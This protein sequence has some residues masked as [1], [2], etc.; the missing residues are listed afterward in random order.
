MKRPLRWLATPIVSFLLALLPLAGF[1]Q[2]K[3]L[4]IDI[5]G[6][7][8]AALPSAVGP[9]AVQGPGAAPSTD[10]A[11]VLRA[12]CGGSGQFRT[13]PD[14]DRDAHHTRGRK[15]TGAARVGR[16]DGVD[17][18]GRR[19]MG[20][21]II[22]RGPGG[23]VDHEVVAGH[24]R[25]TGVRI[26]DVQ[27][28]AVDSSHVVGAWRLSQRGDQVLPEH[29][30]AADDQPATHGFVITVGLRIRRGYRTHSMFEE[31]DRGANQS[32]RWI[33]PTGRPCGSS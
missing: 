5:V 23:D 27:H 30:V 28:V 1:A 18:Q 32:T 26:D 24:K 10:I 21:R 29:P 14:R 13:Q 11:Q 12:A 6:G 8:A 22:D 20:F 7:N 15:A 16:S 2:D 33:T 25:K 3:P 9:M 4:E 31:S 19:F 17:R